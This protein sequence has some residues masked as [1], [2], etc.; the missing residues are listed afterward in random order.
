LN[1]T[2]VVAP[3]LVREFEPAMC[4]A[5][6]E[7]LQ[8]SWRVN[9]LVAGSLHGLNL[10]DTLRTISVPLLVIAGVG[11]SAS[12]ESMRAWT[13]WAPDA[14]ELVLPAPALFPW[15]RSTARFRRA[16]AEFLDGRWPEGAE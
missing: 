6:A 9:R 13:T 3:D 16:A 7:A 8:R 5:P 12:T 14:R 2:P 10:R 1:P 4:D 11:D 15:T